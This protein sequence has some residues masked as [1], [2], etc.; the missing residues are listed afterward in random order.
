MQIS[1]LWRVVWRDKTQPED[2]HSLLGHHDDG[3]V[4]VPCHR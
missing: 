3:G 1:R 4:V 2:S